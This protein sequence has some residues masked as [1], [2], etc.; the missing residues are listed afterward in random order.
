MCCIQV[1]DT[2]D[3]LLEEMHYLHDQ[4]QHADPVSANPDT[5]KEQISENNVSYHTA[6]NIP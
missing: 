3:G 6:T 4:V 1:G 2:V 5:L